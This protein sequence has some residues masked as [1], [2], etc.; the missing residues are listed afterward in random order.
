MSCRQVP[1]R[2][3]RRQT[4]TQKTQ[5]QLESSREFPGQ[6]YSYAK[7]IKLHKTVMF[8]STLAKD[9]LTRTLLE[10]HEIQAKSHKVF[11]SQQCNMQ[12]GWLRRRGCNSTKYANF[13]HTTHTQSQEMTG[14]NF[15]R[16]PSLKLYLTLHWHQLYMDFISCAKVPRVKCMN[17]TQVLDKIQLEGKAN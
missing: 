15:Q 3:N 13:Q 6:L 5:S 10:I 1:C 16:D 14:N 12:N 17:N 2:G 4:K 9:S 7:H 11:G 8:Q